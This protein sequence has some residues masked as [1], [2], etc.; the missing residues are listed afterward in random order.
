MKDDKPALDH[1]LGDGEDFELL[2]AVGAE[3]GRRLL[4]E[5]PLKESRCTLVHIGECVDSGVCLEDASRTKRP[6]PPLGYVHDLA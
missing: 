3:E 4:A 6:L 5:Q 1:A 2:F